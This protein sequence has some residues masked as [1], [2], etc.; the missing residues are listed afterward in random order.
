MHTLRHTRSAA[1]DSWTPLCARRWVNCLLL[2][3]VPFALGFRL[4][5]TY[6][7]E[8]GTMK[9]FLVYVAASFLL[10]WQSA[11]LHADFQAWPPALVLLTACCAGRPSCCWQDF[12]CAHF[13]QPQLRAQIVGSDLGRPPPARLVPPALA[14]CPAARSLPGGAPCGG[15]AHNLLHWPLVLLPAG[16]QLR[17][18]HTA[19]ARFLRGR[20]LPVPFCCTS[21][22]SRCAQSVTAALLASAAGTR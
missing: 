10:H 22:P 5:D 17:A 20:P 4:W 18:L 14:V 12:S 2:R 6:L 21:M 1:P 15:P 7:A 16:F 19:H 3:E 9:E 11:L 8:G 13:T